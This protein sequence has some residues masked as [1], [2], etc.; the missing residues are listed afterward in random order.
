MSCDD[1]W[2]TIYSPSDFQM[3]RTR[4][5]ISSI[6][7]YMKSNRTLIRVLYDEMNKEVKHRGISPENYD[8][9]YNFFKYHIDEYVEKLSEKKIPI[10]DDLAIKLNTVIKK[11]ITRLESV[12]LQSI[13]SYDANFVTH[14]KEIT[15]KLYMLIKN[16]V[17][18]LSEE[19]SNQIVLILFPIIVS[20]IF[21]S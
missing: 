20:I 21:G 4:D 9:F 5:E 8:C 13:K 19:D 2:V 14:L 11:E 12:G 18:I 17:N 7:T 1:E 6:N 10:T 3:L 15:L 16:E